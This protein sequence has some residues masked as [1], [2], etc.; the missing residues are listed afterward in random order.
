MIGTEEMGEEI[1]P[2]PVSA[3]DGDTSVAGSSAMDSGVSTGSS[4]AATRLVLSELLK[5]SGEQQSELTTP[6]F[7]LQARVKA[8]LASASQVPAGAVQA[9]ASQE[10][11]SASVRE[12]NAAESTEKKKE[13]SA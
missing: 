13:L 3:Y 6:L 11:R 9:S 7:E 2:E 12:T 5:S 4:D 8:I 10:Q 1:S